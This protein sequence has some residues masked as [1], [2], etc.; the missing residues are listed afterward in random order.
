MKLFGTI[1]GV[2]LAV[3]LFG[4]LAVGGYFALKFVLDLF[5]TLEPQM[6]TMT[7]IASVVALLCASIIA[8]GFKWTGRKEEEVQVKAEKA[9]LY[10]RIVLIW[11]EKLNNRTKAIEQSMED[12]LQKLERLLTLRGSSKVIKIYIELQGL[13]KNAGLQSREIPS[14][15]ATLILDMRKDLGQS[16]LNLHESDLMKVLSVEVLRSSTVSTPHVGKP[17][18]SLS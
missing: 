11:G 2:V 12:E 14:Q 5:G 17:Q 16:V 13:E 10:E 9:N 1:F 6:A 18:V 8:G 15:V 4:A 3:G 7:A